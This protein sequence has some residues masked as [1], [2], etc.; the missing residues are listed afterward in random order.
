MFITFTFT[1]RVIVYNRDAPTPRDRHAECSL[2]S[3]RAHPGDGSFPPHSERGYCVAR[4][5]AEDSGH[6]M[7]RRGVTALALVVRPVGWLGAVEVE[8]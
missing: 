1:G 3:V 7:C 2:M 4:A 6:A 8:R 5:Q